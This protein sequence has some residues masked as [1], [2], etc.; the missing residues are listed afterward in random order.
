MRRVVLFAI[1]APLLGCGAGSTPA[2]SPS[3]T[4]A[5][6]SPAPA[7]APREAAYLPGF[8]YPDVHFDGGN[9]RVV[10]VGSTIALKTTTYTYNGDNRPPAFTWGL[11]ETD[12]GRIDAQGNLTATAPGTLH[13]YAEVNGQRRYCAIAAIAT[14]RTWSTLPFTADPAF[15][16]HLPRYATY[17]QSADDWTRFWAPFTLPESI[18]PAPAVDFSTTTILAVT[19]VM[20]STGDAH[21]VVL[22]DVVEGASPVYRVSLTNWGQEISGQAITVTRGFFVLPKRSGPATLE[23]SFPFEPAKTL[24]VS[25]TVEAPPADW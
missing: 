2:T 24:P 4:V 20:G 17:L 25:A 19:V 8:N 23:L 16:T 18:P 14:P 6:A 22:T 1:L 15:T 11:L 3:P 7:P 12:K 5:P 9:P 13:A 21:D 10:E